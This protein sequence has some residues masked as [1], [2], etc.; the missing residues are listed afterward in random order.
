[1][2]D[3]ATILVVDDTPANVKLLVDLLAS[4]GYQ[5]VAAASGEQALALIAESPPDLVLL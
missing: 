3:A 5:A 2:K 1:M 4:R